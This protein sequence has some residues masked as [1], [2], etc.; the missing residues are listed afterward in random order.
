MTHVGTLV[1]LH[2]LLESLVPDI[3]AL[4]VETWQDMPA[5]AANAK[6]DSVST[7]LCRL[8]RQSRGSRDLPVRIDTQKVEIDPAAGE[9][10]GRQDIVFSP[11]VPREDIYFC[12]ECKRLNVRTP[13][14]TRAYFAEYVHEGMKR[15]VRGQYSQAVRHGGM[16]A[17][18]LDGKVDPAIAGVEENIKKHHHD[19][20]LD[21]PG[22]FQR[23]SIRPND[24]RVRETRHRRAQ[25]PS[26][27]AI[28]H[29]FMAGDPNA[30]MLPEPAAS[31]PKPSKAKSP[32]RSRPHAHE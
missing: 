4:I 10:Q 30:P 3:L 26:P 13:S 2:N 29:M 17:F 6:E 8:L 1:E 11:M 15:F 12:L 24:E 25:T 22:T 27:I 31:T 16:L 14:G 19:L 21:P 28:H 9:E 32:K 7:S 23:S 20:G 18:V 5:P